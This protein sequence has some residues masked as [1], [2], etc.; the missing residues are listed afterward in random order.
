MA[1]RW[2]YEPQYS[3][4]FLVPLFALLLVWQRRAMRPD[5]GV[6][7]PWGLAL[8]V[9]A[10]GLRLAGAFFYLTW[11]D[12]ISLFPCLLGF[13]LL[14]GGWQGVIW[15]WPA[16]AFLLFM[17]PLPFRLEGALAQPLQSLATQASTFCL[18]VLGFPATAEGNIISI[19]DSKLGVAEACNGLSMLLSFFALT[20]AFALVVRRPRLDK[21]LIL[22]SAVPIALF[23]NVM[24][25]TLTGVLYELVGSAAAKAFFHDVA[26]WFMMLLALGLLWLEMYI[27]SWLFY[28]PD[29][30]EPLAVSWR[31]A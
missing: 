3:H 12:D 10:A 24:R 15:V 4:G 25:I 2:S 14:L 18:L 8:L 9:G 31:S 20:A 11:L 19:N 21:A 27:L 16:I 28:E 7:S 1:Q 17:V 5:P 26:G 6:W 30:S 23:A 22:A 13:T 29:L